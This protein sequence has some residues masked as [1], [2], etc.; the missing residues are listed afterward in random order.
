MQVTTKSKLF[1][2]A[3]GMSMAL[4]LLAPLQAEATVIDFTAMPDGSVSVIGDATFA[5]SGTGEAGS[6]TVG[7]SYGGG[8][9]NSTDGPSYPTNTI[10]SVDFTSGVTGVRWTFDNEGSKAT[11]YTIFD[12]LMNVLATGYNSTPFGF[13]SYD[14]SS[15]TDVRRIEWNNN[16]N[17][18]LFALGKIEY[19]AGS[20]VPEPGALALLSLGLVGV[21]A[22]SRRSKAQ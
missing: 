1:Q 14:F 12:S 20:S 7:S 3:A 21:Y 22:S 6:P 4:S 11:T 15:L 16:G 17:N 10:L 13:Q 5:L 2:A 9:W 19:E 8:L 18:W